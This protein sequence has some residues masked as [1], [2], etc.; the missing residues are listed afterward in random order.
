MASDALLTDYRYMQRAL[1]LARR[2][3]YTTHPNPRVGCVLVRQGEIIAEGWHQRAGG[4]HAEAMALQNCPD[5]HG[6]T[7]YVTL[8]PC[9]HFGKTPPC[10]DAL[11]A[12]G[13]ARV[14]VA[15]QDPNPLVAGRGVAK[16]R[17]A[18]IS[19][20]TGVL[21]E[22]AAALN[23]GF[24]KRMLTGLP[25]TRSKLGCSV[26]GRT[27]LANGASQWITS[28]EARL[29]V[30]R[31]RA[32]SAC[33]LTGVG[34]VLAD[35]PS[36]TVRDTA[37]NPHLAG[38]AELLTPARVI[39][40]SQLRTPT[41]A[42]LASLPGRSIILTCST[43]KDKIAALEQAGFEVIV[44]AAQQKRLD[45]QAVWQTLGQMH[46]NEVL[47]EAGATLNGALLANNLLDELIVYMAP[48]IL[49]DSGR[50]LF[51]L[52]ALQSLADKT[53]LVWR[54]VRPVGPDLRLTLG[55]QGH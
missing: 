16:L 25:Y 18:G 35:D 5:A 47:V 13:V 37:N 15:M 24:I 34:T 4:P 6:A 19:V 36:L 26:D 9:S 11:V 3:W 10:A 14:V 45:L 44:L 31:L 40:D 38:C 50:G 30:Q 27:A 55:I 12:A 23:T 43:A 46:F 21:A 17:A 2:G 53:A 54:E 41:N 28:A 48:S 52:P 39:L 7:A 32:E 33:I 22:Q 51:A 49:G 42:R 8:E 1:D 29:D 20:V